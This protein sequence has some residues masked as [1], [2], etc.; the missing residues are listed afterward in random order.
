MRADDDCCDDAMGADDDCCDDA[1]GADDD[2]YEVMRAM[3]T[4][5]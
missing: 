5:R 1:M 3:A 4:G 2:C